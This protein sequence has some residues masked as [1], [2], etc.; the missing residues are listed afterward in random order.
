MMIHQLLGAD[1][2]FL[3]VGRRP[4]KINEIP[5]GIKEGADESSCAKL[6]A[7]AYMEAAILNELL[8]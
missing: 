7:S 6:N 2:G 3:Y 4:N 8:Q 1:S 5:N